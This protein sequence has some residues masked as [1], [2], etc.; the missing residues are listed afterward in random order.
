MISDTPLKTRIVLV[1]TT[2]AGNIGATAR[3]MKTMGLRDL[4]LVA[5]ATTVDAEAEA[6]S[7]GA[8]DILATASHH[9]ELASAVTDC[10]LVI[11]A[12]ARQRRLAAP[13]LAPRAAIAEIAA[14]GTG[15]RAAVVFGRER[16]GLS[17]EE[18][19]LCQRLMHIPANPD[20]SSLNIAAAVQVIAYE[21]RLAALR[22]APAALEEAQALADH[23][24]MERFYA[25]LETVLLDL[26]F[27]DPANPRHLMRRLRRL[28][29]RAR[30]DHNEINILRG[31]LAAVEGRGSAPRRAKG[32]P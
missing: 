32:K 9:D 17:N 21:L 3:A 16:T 14:L 29:N 12:T 18:L 13:Q 10:S 8:T 4:A 15:Q 26:G 22:D 30:P 7:A 25:H 2:H 20:Y 27:L 23:G 24:E 11:G 5:P 31:I 1:G 28:Y 6:R 19:D